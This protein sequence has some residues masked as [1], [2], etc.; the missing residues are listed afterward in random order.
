MAVPLFW[1]SEP[2]VLSF[3]RDPGFLDFSSVHIGPP[4]VVTRVWPEREDLSHQ[5]KGLLAM[6]EVLLKPGGRCSFR[7]G[8]QEFACFLSVPVRAVVAYREEALVPL[9]AFIFEVQVR[10]DLMDLAPRP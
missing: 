6:L 5:R 4:L 3:I 7:L 1:S 9:Q 10:L 2:S 8:V